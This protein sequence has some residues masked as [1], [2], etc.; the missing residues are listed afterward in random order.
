MVTA[1][2][3]LVA[4][5]ASASTITVTSTSDSGPGSLRQA[6]AEAGSG[7]TILVPASTSHYAITSEP[8]TIGKSLTISRVGPFVPV[9]ALGG[10]GGGEPSTVL[11]AM[12]SPHRVLNVTGGVVTISG[13]TVTGARESLEDGAGIEVAG[14]ANLTLSGVS[15]IGNTVKPN[16]S[17]GGIEALGASTLTINASTIANNRAYNGGGLE[18]D[19]T[20]VITNSTISGNHA[21][22]KGDNGDG[23]GLEGSAG[24]ALTLI[25]DTVANNECFNGPTCGAGIDIA[26]TAKNTIVADN[27]GSNEEATEV[28]PN[29]CDATITSTGPNI[30]NAND[31]AF[32]AHGGMSNTDPLL[33]PLANNGGPTDTQNLLAGSPAIDHGT[34]SGCPSADQRGVPR[35]QGSTCDVG[36]VEHTVPSAGTPVV[37]GVTATSATLRA[38]A[39]A[40]FIG[41]SFS[42]HY[43]TTPSYGSATP[44][45][46]LPESSSSEFATTTLTGLAPATTYHVQLAVSTADGSAASG[47]VAFTTGSAPAAPVP[48]RPKVTGASQSAS[49]WREGRQLAR[50]SRRRKRPPI[51]TTFSFSLNEPA[52]VSFGFAEE[53]AGRRVGHRCLAKTHRNRSRKLCTRTVAAGSLAFSGHSGT[54]SVAFQGRLSAAKTL[55]PGRYALTII[56]TNSAGQRSSPQVL[57]FTIVG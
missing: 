44:T 16:G 4:Q 25:N 24:T 46:P 20:A 52:A 1:L 39:N 28:T 31:C 10:F 13:V 43:G 3:T 14:G 51:G 45:R 56:A 57:H 15:V 47:D 49:R 18:V 23:G 2:F 29:N 6:I 19:G 41:G 21:G 40:V 27:L 48:A 8:L 37:T 33:G 5:S 54:N 35:P 38:T 36:A 30:E 22:A 26:A 17:G 50:F 9:D 12:G 53:L 32:A 34:G 11:D 55:K 7:D 42:Y